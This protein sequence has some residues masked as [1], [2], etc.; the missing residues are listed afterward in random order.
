MSLLSLTG[1]TT[2]S[3]YW[4]CLSQ[5]LCVSE[6]HKEEMVLFAAVLL[7]ITGTKMGQ[8]Q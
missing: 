8:I 4:Q 2:C 6:E 5:L 3:P 1:A 7:S